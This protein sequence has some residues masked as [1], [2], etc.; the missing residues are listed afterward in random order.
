MFVV[1]DLTKEMLENT[2]K[3]LKD[4]E[5]LTYILAD[6]EALPFLDQS[7]DVVTCRIAPHHFP[8][9][10]KFI[11]EVA[12][13]LAPDGT[14]ILIDNVVPDDRKLATFMNMFEKLRD[15]S[16]VR[17]LIVEGMGSFTRRK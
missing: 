17:V 10:D 7:F 14:F 12:R 3:H 15:D 4:F 13:V 2:K 11:E 1:T 6:A 8:N 9:P 16:H 5:N